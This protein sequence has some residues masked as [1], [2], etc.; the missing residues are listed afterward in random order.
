MIRRLINKEFNIT[1]ATVLITVI[2]QFLFIR[3]ASYGI[4][5]NDF[6]NFVL[7]QTLIVGLSALFLQIPGQS[8]DRFYN[9][10]LQKASFINEFRTMLLAINALSF[11]VVFLYGLAI[12]KFTT[13]ILIVVFIYFVLLNSY[14]LNQKIL[15]LDLQREKY[16]YTRL[17]EALS[18]FILPIFDMNNE[19]IWDV[20]RI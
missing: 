13:E 7:L 3:Y 12:D 16:F 8:F 4:E 6:G 2:M 11:F 10:A 1:V 5:K 18:K 9:A 20:Q 19:K 15:L 17:L 14:E